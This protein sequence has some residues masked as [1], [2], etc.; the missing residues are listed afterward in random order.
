MRS[1]RTET[2][3][4][5]RKASSKELPFLE[6]S[7]IFPW[8]R[9]KKSYSY[10]R[11]YQPTISLLLE[12]QT[13]MPS[14]KTGTNTAVVGPQTAAAIPNP[15]MTRNRKAKMLMRRERDL[16]KKQREWEESKNTKAFLSFKGST[17]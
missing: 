11:L 3:Q 4:T 15:K 6:P 2:G 8:T 5:L 9:S 17:K 1:L 14:P 10:N 12:S 13:P 7:V 16:S